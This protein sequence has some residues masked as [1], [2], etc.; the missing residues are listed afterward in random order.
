[1][2]SGFAAA[3]GVSEAVGVTMRQAERRHEVGQRVVL[4]AVAIAL[5]TVLFGGINGLIHR[6]V[7]RMSGHG[8]IPRDGR[9]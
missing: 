8:A 4:F 7:R 5:S 2:S 9:A 3:I 6:M 1:M